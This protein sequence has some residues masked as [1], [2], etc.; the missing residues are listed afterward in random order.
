MFCGHNATVWRA[1]YYGR[2]VS[3][4]IK[5]WIKIC[6]Q[7]KPDGDLHLS[8]GSPAPGSWL[9]LPEYIHSELTMPMACLD[10]VNSI[11]KKV[12]VFEGFF[13]L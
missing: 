1:L 9:F 8:H 3:S 5:V 13:V 12:D 10:L 7:S 4:K 11:D 2:F 6:E